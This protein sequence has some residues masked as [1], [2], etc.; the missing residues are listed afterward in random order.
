M[1]YVRSFGVAG[2]YLLEVCLVGRTRIDDFKNQV[3]SCSQL[4]NVQ[5]SYIAFGYLNES[6]APVHDVY[7][8]TVY[9]NRSRSL[10]VKITSYRSQVLSFAVENLKILK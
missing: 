2:N 6:V 3:I 1:V 4:N 7:F 5:L 9:C 8:P 10:E